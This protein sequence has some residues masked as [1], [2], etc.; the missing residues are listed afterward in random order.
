MGPFRVHM[1]PCRGPGP[2]LAVA[3]LSKTRPEIPY[4]VPGDPFGRL[5]DTNG[6]QLHLFGA[7]FTPMCIKQDALHTGA[8]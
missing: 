1:E 7:A 8:R 3:G 2:S 5:C 4:W 6:F